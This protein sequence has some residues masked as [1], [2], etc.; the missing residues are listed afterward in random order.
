M[1]TERSVSIRCCSPSDQEPVHGGIRPQSNTCIE[2]RTAGVNQL[3]ELTI[4][5]VE[6]SSRRWAVENCIRNRAFE[7]NQ[8]DVREGFS[9]HGIGFHTSSGGL[10]ILVEV[11]CNDRTDPV[12]VWPESSAWASSGGAWARDGG[13]GAGG[14]GGAGRRGRGRL[15][16]RWHG[17]GASG[18]PW[19]TLKVP[20]VE[21]LAMPS[22]HTNGG[23][24]EVE[25]SALS[26]Y[27]VLAIYL[28]AMHVE[29]GRGG[30]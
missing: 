17:G 20:I 1:K 7:G 2:K 25:A 10:Q 12:V 19:K 28:R 18:V 11:R 13:H 8:R 3:Y 21:F 29:S 24:N 15:S 26:N 14:N 30:D 4:H 27:V 23:P 16:R 5:D 6:L 22:A 9:M